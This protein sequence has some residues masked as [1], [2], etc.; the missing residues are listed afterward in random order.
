MTNF[1]CSCLPWACPG[2]HVQTKFSCMRQLSY[3]GASHTSR[4]KRPSHLRLVLWGWSFFTLF[5][6]WTKTTGKAL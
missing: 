2:L 1:C 6:A 4:T 3:L 5:C